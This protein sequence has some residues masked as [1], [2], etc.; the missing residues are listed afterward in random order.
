VGASLSR[1]GRL[2]QLA[3]PAYTRLDARAEWR[4]NSRLSAAAVGQN[5]LSGH[6]PEFS[7][8]VLF[9]TS[10]VPRSARLDLRWE[11]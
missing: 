5:L 4:L 9:L 3:V 10:S 6:H 2:R 1:V 11:F 7:S 8:A